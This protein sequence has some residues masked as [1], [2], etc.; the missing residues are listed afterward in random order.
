M[1]MSN[2]SHHNR[3]VD[4]GCEHCAEYAEAYVLGIAD[5]IDAERIEQHLVYC[6]RCRREIAQQKHV[7]GYLPYAT[8]L[9]EPGA[10]VRDTLLS[11]IAAEPEIGTTPTLADPWRPNALLNPSADTEAEPRTSR[12]SGS[13]PSWVL[14]SLFAPLALTLIILGAWANSL[15][16]D[17]RTLRSPSSPAE[18]TVSS[19]GDVQLYSME[20]NCTEC[21]HRDASGQLGGNPDETT[22]V[23]IAWNLNPDEQHQ[24]WCVDENGE[25]ILVSDLEVAQ[26]G[27]VF[28]TVN[29]P[30]ALGGY[31]HVYVARSDG[32]EELVVALND[33]QD[34]NPDGL[35]PEPTLTD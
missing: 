7:V 4:P 19:V 31:Q 15:H 12:F 6:G 22:G 25:K 10:D 30:A 20:P 34:A 14:P 24:V 21:E 11:R 32:T 3:T 35:T 16:G 29:F 2:Q 13:M 5:D 26:S 17:L 9:A 1:T 23:V 33:P 27:D 8:P 28:Q 18:E